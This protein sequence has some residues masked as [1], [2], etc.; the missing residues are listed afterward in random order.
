MVRLFLVLFTL[1]HSRFALLR[2]WLCVLIVNSE[3]ESYKV[4]KG[5][6]GIHATHTTA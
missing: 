6:Y 4:I 3:Y 1:G 2:D 5:V